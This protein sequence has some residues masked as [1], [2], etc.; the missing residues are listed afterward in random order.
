MTFCGISVALHD[1]IP[2]YFSCVIYIWSVM[3]L[4][5]PR[6]HPEYNPQIDMYLGHEL[7]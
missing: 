6:V 4:F 1:K 7:R 2:D 3:F 5:W